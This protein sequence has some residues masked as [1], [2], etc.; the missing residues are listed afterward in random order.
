MRKLNWRWWLA[1][2]GL[3]LAFILLQLPASLLAYAV[4]QGSQERLL[5]S[6]AQGTLWQGSAGQLWQGENAWQTAMNWQ[7]QKPSLLRGR[8]EW[9]WNSQW[10][11][12]AGQGRLGWGMGGAKLEQLD[13]TVPAAPVLAM[14]P[15]LAQYQFSGLLQLRSQQIQLATPPQGALTI[16]WLAASSSLAPGISNLGNY[17][18]ELTPTNTRSE[19]RWQ[20]R[21][22][23]LSGVLQINGHGDIGLEGHGQASLTL[24]AAAGHEQALAA[25]LALLGSGN[26]SG[27]RSL[28]FN[29]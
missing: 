25:L 5:L 9:Q 11:E 29:L 27:E 20:W 17:R 26:G 15:Q 2:S 7:W 21:L 14:L 12:H 1:L 28:R 22:S 6:S 13:L 24:R 8:L 18:L 4:R 3:T 19:S 16:D 10:Q 23:T